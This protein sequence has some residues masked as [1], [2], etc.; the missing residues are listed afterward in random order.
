MKRFVIL[1]VLMSIIALLYPVYLSITRVT[2][3]ELLNNGHKQAVFD[4]IYNRV[5]D[6]DAYQY[7]LD[8]FNFYSYGPSGFVMADLIT[9]SLW[10]MFDEESDSGR[11]SYLR[12]MHLK[13]NRREEGKE[14]PYMREKRFQELSEKEVKVYTEFRERISEK[15]EFPNGRKIGYWQRRFGDI[16]Y[17]RYK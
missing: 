15:M 9:G 11:R 16:D 12:G 10:I 2:R 6:D 14:E 5:I 13:K 4:V 1:I 3:F 8:E 7:Y 17:M